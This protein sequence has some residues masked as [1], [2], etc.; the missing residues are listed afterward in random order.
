VTEIGKNLKGFTD[1][2]TTLMARDYKGLHVYD[3][4]AVMEFSDDG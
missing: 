4:T 1:T 2:A 3:S